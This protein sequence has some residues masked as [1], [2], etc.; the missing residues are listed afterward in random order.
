MLTDEECSSLQ[1]L[2]VCPLRRAVLREIVELHLLVWKCLLITRAAVVQHDQGWA[3]SRC[4]KPVFAVIV[5]VFLSWWQPAQ[6]LSFPWCTGFQLQLPTL[7]I[8]LSWSP[9]CLPIFQLSCKGNKE[10][11]THLEVVPRRHLILVARGPAPWALGP[12]TVTST[13]GPG[14]G[15][16]VV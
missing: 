1:G 14:I 5:A 16:K 4:L 6:V 15:G 7:A 2:G 10:E 12:G 9:P 11:G 8:F 13:R 3:L